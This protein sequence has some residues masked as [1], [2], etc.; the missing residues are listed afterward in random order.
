MACKIEE[1]YYPKH[2]EFQSITD[3][4]CTL[5]EILELETKILI[6]LNWMVNPVTINY[7]AN[8]Y[9]LRWEQYSK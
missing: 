6:K 7:W 8:Y 4:N 2:R 5:E 3:D 9:M 1:I